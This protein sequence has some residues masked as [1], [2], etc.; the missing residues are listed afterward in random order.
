MEKAISCVDCDSLILF[1][2]DH[3]DGQNRM[4]CPNC[5]S[6]RRAFSVHA[7]TCL[8]IGEKLRLKHKVEGVKGFVY[9]ETSGADLCHDT[10][11]LNE[12]IRIFD[13]RRIGTA[14]VLRA[15][16]DARWRNP[17][18]EER[19]TCRAPGS[20]SAKYRLPDPPHEWMAVAAYYLWE[21]RG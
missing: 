20:R 15:N 9:D 17:H 16:Q 11:K 10:G 4:P 2:S 19:T 6:T 1:T 7:M 5:Q 13:M 8:Q 21:H 3:D 14:L 18:C 12:L